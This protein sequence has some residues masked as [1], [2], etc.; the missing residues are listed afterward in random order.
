[1]HHVPTFMESSLQ[2]LHKLEVYNMFIFRHFLRI[3][4][5]RR[6]LQSKWL[7][8]K[9]CSL[10]L[11][12][13]S[14]RAIVTCIYADMQIAEKLIWQLRHETVQVEEGS[15]LKPVLWFSLLFSIFNPTLFISI[16]VLK[17]SNILTQY[18]MKNKN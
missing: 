3:M 4:E 8:Q 18:L 9:T 10:N 15:K 7:Q 11:I 6:H 13:V 2:V 5:A 16:L 14:R 12:H 1:M 17:I